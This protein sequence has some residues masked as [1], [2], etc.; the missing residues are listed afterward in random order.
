MTRWN[1]WTRKLDGWV[2][3][4]HRFQE[5]FVKK[6]VGTAKQETPA[7]AEAT[8]PANRASVPHRGDE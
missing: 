6:I 5:M 4:K 1:A 8:S 2:E 3:R 7:S